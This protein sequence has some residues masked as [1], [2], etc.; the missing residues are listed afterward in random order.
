MLILS[1]IQGIVSCTPTNVPLWE[2][3]IYALYSG[4]LWIVLFTSSSYKIIII[5]M[6]HVYNIA[7]NIIKQ[8]YQFNKHNVSCKY[9]LTIYFTNSNTPEFIHSN[10]QTA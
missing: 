2:I 5:V 6:G 10:E 9:Y 8:T 7:W 4:H 1:L 3:P